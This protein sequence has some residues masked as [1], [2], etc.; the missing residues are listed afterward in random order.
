MIGIKPPK[1]YSKDLEHIEK[2]NE[3]FVL[4]AV[5]HLLAAHEVPLGC[6][7]QE[8]SQI[9][10]VLKDVFEKKGSVLLVE[11]APGNGKTRLVRE[12]CQKAKERSASEFSRA[13]AHFQNNRHSTRPRHGGRVSTE[14]L[15][16]KLP[17]TQKQEPLEKVQKKA[18]E[19]F[20]PGSRRFSKKVSVMLFPEVK[21]MEEESLTQELF[22]R[23]IVD[24]IQKL[25]LH[26][27]YSDPSD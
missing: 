27:G 19:E 11:G 17:E 9:S 12:L 15:A 6:R 5:N 14:P 23:A 18:A 4:G 26:S 2:W 22:Y 20:A 25:S 1:G 10:S 24:F 16:Y 7:N 13:N 8:L 21:D 3:S